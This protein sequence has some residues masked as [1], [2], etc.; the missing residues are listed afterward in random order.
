MVVSYAVGKPMKRRFQ[1]VT[2]F[3]LITSCPLQKLILGPKMTKN[4]CPLKVAS[5][6][7]NY[8]LSHKWPFMCN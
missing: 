6:T 7:I 1:K 3:D 8:F 2:K 5:A 4:G